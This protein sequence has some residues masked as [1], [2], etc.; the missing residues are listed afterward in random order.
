MDTISRNWVSQN[1]VSGGAA[2]M[3]ERYSRLRSFCFTMFF[4]L[5]QGFPIILLLFIFSFISVSTVAFCTC[6]F[7]FLVL[8]SLWDER[9]YGWTT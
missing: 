5:R 6:L 9:G 3:K 4:G 7:F 8:V 2:V 1:D